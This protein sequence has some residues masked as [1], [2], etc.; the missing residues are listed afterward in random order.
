MTIKLRKLVAPIALSLTMVGCVTVTEGDH[1]QPKS[2]PI[3]M[4]EARINLGIGYMEN[5]VLIRARKNLELALEH[6]P[7]Y[8]RAQIAM[9]HFYDRVGE[10]EK[11]REMYEDSIRVH[12]NNGNVL[13]NFATFLCKNGE[14][15]RADQMFMKSAE[16]PLYYLMSASY[17]NAAF[18]ALKSKDK[19]KAYLYFSRALD[20]EPKRPKSIINLAN[21]EIER[22]EYS[23]ARIRLI[24]FQTMYGQQT[25]SLSLLTEL[26]TQ[27]GNHTVA[28]QYQKRLDK[29]LA[30]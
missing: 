8:Y 16:Q 18:C 23:S 20:H 25:T 13:N 2:S 22:A 19:D 10:P 5:G 12:P 6:A 24:K 1:I 9:A 26:E 14:Y 17:E 21:L 29:L 27:A 7:T 30:Q 15:E 3:E 11:A 28:A 4:S